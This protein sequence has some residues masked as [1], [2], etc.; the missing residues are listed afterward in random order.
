MSTGF[1]NM[2]SFPCN[3]KQKGMAKSIRRREEFLRRA[4]CDSDSDDGNDDES[5]SED[6]VYMPDWAFDR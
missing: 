1:M 3:K 2:W 6:D 5:S 4:L